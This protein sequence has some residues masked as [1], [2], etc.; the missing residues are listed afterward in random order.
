MEFEI[1]SNEIKDKLREM[2]IKRFINTESDHYK[3]YIAILK[4]Y[5]DG[6]CYDGYLWDTLKADYDKVERT[7]EQAISYLHNKNYVMVMWDIYSIK[8]VN[9][10][11]ILS[12]DYPKGSII[13]I[14]SNELCRYIES[15]WCDFHSSKGFLPED[16][17]IFDE[18]MDWSVIFT[19]EGYDNFTNPELAEDVYIRICFVLD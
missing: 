3:N 19:H 7:I 9:D 5:P 15:E 4:E 10:H 17:Y 16:I 6:L 11:K 8:R 18:T 13:K 12:C 1:V 14:D 2:Y